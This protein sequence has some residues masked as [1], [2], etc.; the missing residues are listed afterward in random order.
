MAV[1]IE[2]YSSVDLTK[3]GVYAYAQSSDFEILLIGYQT[4]GMAQP[5][6]IEAAGLDCQSVAEF[7]PAFWEA[8]LS[9]DIIKTAYNAN[10]ERTCLAR[11]AGREMPPVQW[12]CTAV[13][14]ATLGL[15]RSLEEAGRA[16]GLPEDQQK[17]AIGKALIKYFC[18]PCK[19]TKANGGRTRN[20]PEDAPDKWEQ[21]KEYNAQDVVTERAIKDR[22]RRYPVPEEEER[23]WELDQEIND[24]G[25]LLDMDLV[26]KILRFDKVYQDRLAGEARE[27]TGLEN[28]NSVAQLKDWF[29]EEYG[30]S[31]DSLNKDVIG[32]LREQLEKKP[33][34]KKG[35]RLLEIRQEMAKTSTKKYTAMQNAV[36]P[37]GRLR[38][39]L[40]FYGA[41]RTGR[42][43]G[44]I[45][46]PH[47]LPQNKIPDLA[48]VRQLVKEEDFDSVS[49]L[50]GGIPF[51]F[52]QLIRTAL[53][54]SE[55]RILVVSDF[56]AIEARVIAWL[57]GEEWVLEVFRTH[58]KIYEATAAQMFHVP[59]ETVT[60]GSRLR[61]QGKITQL[62]LGYQGS[63][64]A[65]KAMDKAG[66]IP[67]EEIPSLVEAWRAANPHIVKYWY[68]VEQAAKTAIRER[69][70][71]RLKQGVELFF[72]DGILFVRLPSGRK[73]AYYDAKIGRNRMEREAILY[74][75]V[76]QGSKHWGR[77]ETYGGKLVENIVQATARDCLAV[78]MRRIAGAGYDIVSHV[79]DEII[80]DVPAAQEEQGIRDITEIFSRPIPWAPG[81][82]LKGE[83]YSTPFYKKD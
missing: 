65:M 42:W 37:D 20:R 63:V 27:L 40:Q 7:Y 10:F 72:R 67:E 46:Q 28:P 24:R 64:G 39:T 12:R 31:I 34:P 51:V 47:N 78:A 21:F 55:G 33:S 68:L 41:N 53:T 8:L 4:E 14:A 38:G 79:H 48:E 44:K 9:P 75:G 19:P 22:L 13:H 52:S 43:S 56:S 30:L 81:L 69:R 5:E 80:C 2:S 83:T 26:Q 16:L 1:D 50:Y 3:S 29:R 76:E 60:K 23:L 61:Q 70:T 71:V 57:A 58:G 45:V 77:Q 18:R 59:I 32:G 11:W 66:T 6:V 82:P 54:A 35:L 36:C 62:A 25:I 17:L 73:L 15:P 74:S 49:L